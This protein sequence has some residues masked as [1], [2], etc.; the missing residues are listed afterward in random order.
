MNV[1]YNI[2]SRPYVVTARKNGAEIKLVLWA[3]NKKDLQERLKA[4][5]SESIE[6]VDIRER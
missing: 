2:F 1:K 3:E 4:E 5:L 6:I